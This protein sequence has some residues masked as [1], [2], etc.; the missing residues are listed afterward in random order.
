MINSIK[1]GCVSCRGCTGR[2]KWKR[3]FTWSRKM[4]NF[5]WTSAPRKTV[6]ISF[7]SFYLLTLSTFFFSFL[8]DNP[9]KTSKLDGQKDQWPFAVSRNW[10]TLKE[11]W[12]GFK[13][14]AILV[15]S[16]NFSLLWIYSSQKLRYLCFTCLYF[17]D[18]FSHSNLPFLFSFSP[19]SL[20]NIKPTNGANSDNMFLMFS[21]RP[22]CTWHFLM[23]G[24]M[25]DPTTNALMDAIEWVLARGYLYLITLAEGP[26][27]DITI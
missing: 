20:L 9:K 1:A 2:W 6:F 17:H 19:F 22:P 8:S 12:E 4:D 26:F 7:P 5:S 16:S 23:K 27:N 15:P 18:F 25:L 10:I 14:S 3:V 11:F 13:I 21:R 24:K